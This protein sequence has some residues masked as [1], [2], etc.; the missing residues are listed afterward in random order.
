[1]K[2]RLSRPNRNHQL[3]ATPATSVSV[4]YEQPTKPTKAWVAAVVTLLGLLGIH[5][6]TGTAQ[7]LVMAGQLILVVYGVWRARNRPKLPNRG[8]GVSGFYS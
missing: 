1:M 3:P 4:P 8:R 6:T 7:A 5:I 2:H